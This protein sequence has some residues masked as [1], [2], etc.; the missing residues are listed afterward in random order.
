M[1][2]EQ[3]LRSLLK[4]VRRTA[5]A[6]DI[7]SRQI[8]REIGLTLPQLIVLQCVRDLGEVTGRAISQQA[9]LSPPTV[10]GILD[11]LEAKQLIE[12]YRSTHDRRI[13]HTRLT[14]RGQEVLNTF[15]SVFGNRFDQR[16]SELPGERR[17][18]IL[19]AFAEVADL[20][21]EP[22]APSLDAETGS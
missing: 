13:V 10:L 3:Q 6:V 5:R 7:R 15:P 22:S 20:M 17:Q 18:V 2:V 14:A 16:F 12:R 11:K 9:D 21:A 1:P 19:D 8:D 4:S